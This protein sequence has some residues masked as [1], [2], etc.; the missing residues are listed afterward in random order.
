MT[1]ERLINGDTVRSL[2]V[3]GT[4][5]T[6][7]RGVGVC[8]VGNGARCVGNVWQRNRIRLPFDALLA[9]RSFLT[10]DRNQVKVR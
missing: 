8:R 7:M 10:H 1:I 2:A 6:R 3:G 9:P 5:G 4:V